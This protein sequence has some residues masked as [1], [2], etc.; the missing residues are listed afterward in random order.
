MQGRYDMSRIGRSP[1]G[2]TAAAMLLAALAGCYES[3]PQEPLTPQL[4]SSSEPSLV[5]CRSSAART[6]RGTLGP[7]GGAI[8]LDGHSLSLPAG[9]VDRETRFTLTVPES[10]YVEIRVTA[11]GQ[12]GFEFLEPVS[13]TISYERC[14]RSSW[15]NR[16]LQ[17]YKIDPETG[18]LLRAMGGTDDRVA[19]QVTALSDSLSG[20][21][22]AQ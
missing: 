11:D 20:Y 12:D 2:F 22:I 5:E 14:G 18:A 15:G 1:I 7:A 13:L 21:A 16:P 3:T 8:G 6:A 10:R 9:A 19:R 4:S 17:I